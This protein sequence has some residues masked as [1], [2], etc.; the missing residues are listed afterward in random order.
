MSFSPQQ[1]GQL[2]ALFTQRVEQRAAEQ[3]SEIQAQVG[4]RFEELQRLT[5]TQAAAGSS[6]EQQ[7]QEARSQLQAANEELEF[8]RSR[9]DHA[10]AANAELTRQVTEQ[11]AQLAR[12]RGEIGWP[13]E[14][15]DG[16]GGEAHAPNKCGSAMNAVHDR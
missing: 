3:R 6:L 12:D 11:Q 8:L 14:K 15:R 13:S 2:E 10:N 16:P 4:A 5:Q 1:L 7:L 9:R